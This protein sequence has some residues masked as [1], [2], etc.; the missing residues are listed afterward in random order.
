MSLKIECNGKDYVQDILLPCENWKSNPIHKPEM[1][2]NQLLDIYLKEPKWKMLPRDKS[3]NLH[4]QNS[5]LEPQQSDEWF[6]G[7]L[8]HCLPDQCTCRSTN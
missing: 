5:G 8:I 4:C 6:Q 7:P 1:E 3:N 2:F